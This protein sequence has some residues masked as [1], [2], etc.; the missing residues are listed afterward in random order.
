MGRAIM[1]NAESLDRAAAARH[2]PL[3]RNWAANRCRSQ[4]LVLSTHRTCGEVRRQLNA[5]AKRTA[6]TE[7]SLREAVHALN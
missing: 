7:H 4:G 2:I 5:L 6:G 1:K 3:I